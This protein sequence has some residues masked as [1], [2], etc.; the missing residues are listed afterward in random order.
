MTVSNLFGPRNP[1]IHNHYYNYKYDNNV[2]EFFMN[3]II[4]FKDYCKLAKFIDENQSLQLEQHFLNSSKHNKFKYCPDPYDGW[5]KMAW[6]RFE[7]DHIIKTIDIYKH[8]TDE[9]KKPEECLEIYINEKKINNKDFNNDLLKL[10]AEIYQKLDNEN[11]VN[12][13]FNFLF[14]NR[15]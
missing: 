3:Y 12:T 8:F 13:V 11:Y 15:N 14:L 7:L 10:F 1:Q 9:D 5:H 4:M 6:V 2:L